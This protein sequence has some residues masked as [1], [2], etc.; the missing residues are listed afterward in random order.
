[1]PVV[2]YDTPVGVGIG[3][4][5]ALAR[6]D[7][8]FDPYRWR[9]VLR[10]LITLNG[11]PGGGVDSPLQETHVQGDFPGLLGGRLRLEYRVAFTRRSN[12]AFHGFGN[13]PV[14]GGG[15]D[16]KYY[17]YKRIYPSLEVVLRFGV[18]D[19]LELFVSSSLIF[20]HTGTCGTSMLDDVERGR[21]GAMSQDLLN[22]TSP[23]LEWVYAG[24]V[25]VDTRDDEFHPTLG[26]FHDL[27]LRL[28]PGLMGE[29]THGG[30][31]LTLRLFLPLTR[32]IPHDAWRDLG[33]LAV[34]IV[35]DVL[36][37]DPPFYEMARYGGFLPEEGPGGRQGVRGIPSQRYHGKLKLFGNV[38][39]RIKLPPFPTRKRNFAIG[40]A[41]FVDFGRVWADTRHT[42][43]LDGYDMGVQW[44]VGAGGRA[45]WGKQFVIRSDFGYCPRLRTYGIQ[46]YLG[47]LF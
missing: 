36:M 40:S 47:H 28:S 24:G 12:T 30:A 10:L 35:A 1:M 5:A 27:S 32:W 13:L 33:V 26:V 8:D 21:Y 31:N 22:G 16:E 45:F 38:E 20:N 46:V 11:A 25:I 39:L 4:L 37:G 44:C 23:H 3:G 2:N 19:W 18:L 42:P 43:S 17:L 41:W 34:R 7:P 14:T 29:P 6:Y 15:H 9:L